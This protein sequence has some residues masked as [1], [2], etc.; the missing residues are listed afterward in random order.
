MM[1]EG[2][3]TVG[4]V[5]HDAQAEALVG[6]EAEGERP[7]HRAAGDGC[8][9]SS[10][11]RTAPAAGHVAALLGEEYSRQRSAPV[12]GEATSAVIHSKVG[13]SGML[14]RASIS[15]S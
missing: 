10:S 9:V 6:A 14:G 3:V 11:A 4:Q 13:S 2:F 7:R 8:R 12:V 15:P 1:T 5:R